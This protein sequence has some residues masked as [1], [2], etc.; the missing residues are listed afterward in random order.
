MELKPM[1]KALSVGLCLAGT[2]AQA[3][4]FRAATFNAANSP[5]ASFLQDFADYVKA[6]TN[7]EIEFELF[8]GG[9]LLP[10]EGTLVG[11]QRD[12][13]QIANINASQIPS[14]MPYDNVISDLGFIGDDQ[15]ALAFAKYL[16]R[17]TTTATCNPG[18]DQGPNQ[19]PGRDEEGIQRLQGGFAGRIHHLFVA[20]VSHGYDRP[21]VFDHAS[22][23]RRTFRADRLQ[24]VE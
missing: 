14:D 22:K 16:G 8:T 20:V 17:A 11:L 1:L 4:T 10:G 24:A 7:D 23:G 5:N 19:E 12:V 13:A 21:I 15:M 9:S 18:L 3:E 2:A 6:G